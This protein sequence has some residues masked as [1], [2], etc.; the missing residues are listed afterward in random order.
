VEEKL[1]DGDE[2]HGFISSA[3]LLQALDR[4]E[5]VRFFMLLPR[6]FLSRG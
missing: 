1:K 4:G 2:I 6:A 5:E 3:Q